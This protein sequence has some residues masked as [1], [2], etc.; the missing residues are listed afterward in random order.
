MF[1]VSPQG[2]IFYTTMMEDD[3]RRTNLLTGPFKDSQLA[4]TFNRAVLISEPHIS[5][6]EYFPPSKRM[7]AFMG[8]PIREE[9]KVIGV[10]CMQID[11]QKIKELSG[12]YW[13]LGKTEEMVFS[14][15]RGNHVCIVAPLRHAPDAAF[16]K[17]IAIGSDEAIPIQMAAQ[18]RDG[19]GHSVDYRGIDI[20][21]VWRHLHYPGWGLV[22]KMDA[23]EVFTPALRYKT[24]VSILGIATFVVVVIATVFISRSI[25][26]PIIK[27]TNSTKAIALGDFSHK[28]EIKSGDEI[29]L[30]SVSF[31]KMAEQLKE[32]KEEL[33]IRV[34]ERTESLFKSESKIR[35]IVENAA[36]AIITINEHGVIDMFN[37]TA[38]KMF[39]YRAEEVRGKNVSML[40][41]QPYKDEH[42]G[43]IDNYIS[44]GVKNVIG[45][46]REV[47]G[48]R[49]NGE[50]FPMALSVAEVETK[51]KSLRRERGLQNC[52]IKLP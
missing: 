2:G 7:S 14:E 12:R 29:G 41:P 1:L 28:V 27:L 40:M 34:Q 11:D 35:A 31:N 37:L 16:K 4:H 33:E 5:F 32:S 26:K 22:V 20:I 15:K 42:D 46:G 30:L 36:D 45:I 18:A 25:S 21:A 48:L 47:V 10:V 51:G 3:Y 13:G 43:Y 9:G 17:R 6:F 23:S 49:K 24:W 19:V 8:M 52:S 39:G 44:T 50:S 38:E